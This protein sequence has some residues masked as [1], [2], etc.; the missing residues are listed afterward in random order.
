MWR[1]YLLL[2]DWRQPLPRWTAMLV[3][4][5]LALDGASIARDLLS[6]TTVPKPSSIPDVAPPPRAAVDPLRVVNAHL[7]G[8][9]QVAPRPG[10]AATA[11]DTQLDL[12]L[13]GIIA[14][15]NPDLG[16]AIL[17]PKGQPAHLYQVGATLAEAAGTRLY[18][19]F[20][21]RVVLDRDGQLETLKLP[22]RPLAGGNEQAAA[23]GT[24]AGATDTA[25]NAVAPASDAAQSWFA[26]NLFPREARAV[27]KP[28]GVSLHPDGHMR[29]V[30]DL[31]PGDLVTS[32][33]GVEIS[34]M[35]AL[36]D[37]LKTAGKTVSFTVQRGGI[38]HTLS[39][40]P[41]E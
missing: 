7:F 20:T 41:D 34:N 29:E 40:T 28:A 31:R 32:V 11:R 5:L 6:F 18:R 2:L 36:Q 3:A 27:G 33:N 15:R 8:T 14:T 35:D 22:R 26:N 21:D 12:V 25:S 9:D 16:F 24:D 23:T 39:V 1:T 19:I 13:S 38:E 4:A 37:A 10:D 30:Y 17:G